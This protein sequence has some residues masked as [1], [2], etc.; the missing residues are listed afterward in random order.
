MINLRGG[1]GPG[2]EEKDEK[3]V[4]RCSG[5]HGVRRGTREGTTLF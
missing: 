1:T 5:C 2:T 3:D 4:L